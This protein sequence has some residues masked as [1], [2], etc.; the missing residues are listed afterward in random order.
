MNLNWVTLLSLFIVFGCNPIIAKDIESDDLREMGLFQRRDLSTIGSRIV[1]NPYNFNLPASEVPV[2]YS[3]SDVLPLNLGYLTTNCSKRQEKSRFCREY[4]NVIQIRTLSKDGCIAGRAVNY[5]TE[6]LPYCL[7]FKLEYLDG[8][9]LKGYDIFY[10]DDVILRNI[11]SDKDVSLRVSGY[12]K[13]NTICANGKVLIIEGKDCKYAIN[14]CGQDMANVKYYKSEEDLELGNNIN[15]TTNAQ[16]WSIDIEKRKNFTISVSFVLP[17]VTNEKLTTMVLEPI[18]NNSAKETLIKQKK[19]WNDFLENRVPHPTRFDLNNIDTK[20]VGADKVKKL[21]YKAWVALAQNVL[22]PE[23]GNYPYWQLVTGKSSLW[24]EGHP[25]LPFSA[26]WESF[27]GLQLFAYVD[28]DIAW[29]CLKGL[30]SLIN[31]EG[32]L[33]GESLPSRK[34]H[35]A[36]ILYNLSKDKESLAEVYP[37]IAR[38]LNWRLTQPRWIYGNATPENE[39]D[40]EFVVSVIVDM[41]YMYEIAKVLGRSKEASE[42]LLKRNNYI[43]LYKNWFWI[44]PKTKPVQFLNNNPGRVGFPI[45]IISG[46]VLP[47]LDGEYLESM[48]DLFYSVYNPDKVFAGIAAPKYPDMDFTIYGLIDKG[49]IEEAK[50]LMETFIRDVILTGEVF[51]ET[52]FD[53]EGSPAPGGVRPS[54]FGLAGVIDFVMLRNNY[55]FTEGIPKAINLYEDN[56]SLEGI[57]VCGQKLNIVKRV[58]KK[59]YIKQLGCVK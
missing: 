6:W 23:E 47:E 3:N 17:S 43:S 21:Y 25:A 14:V 30:L 13:G 58:G 39:K 42:W 53:K 55:M 40:A 50:I 22:K 19:Y 26:A 35:S 46:L 57:K 52:Y 18:C 36:W 11:E 12:I 2:K 5:S 41:G 28:V 7:P 38:Y 33:G 34:A 9:F 20:G 10:S 56:T 51:A 15:D 1:L 49:K 24:D 29:S 45:Q 54:I 8:I 31:E 37:S 27:V 32:M 48:M 16:Y 59:S 4:K 44:T